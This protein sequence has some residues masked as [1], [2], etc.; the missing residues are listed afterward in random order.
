MSVYRD[1]NADVVFEHPHPGPL[2]ATVYRDGVSIWSA[3]DL[4]PATPGRYVISLTWKETAVDGTLSIVWT[5][6]DFTRQQEVEVVTPVVSISRLRTI[7]DDVNKTDAELAELEVSVRTI[8]EAYTGQ[9]FNYS[10]G[11]KQ[12]RTNGG[13]AIL[14]DRLTTLTSVTGPQGYT[15]RVGN[16]GFTVYSQPDPSALPT[17]EADVY[18]LADDHVIRAPGAKVNR[19]QDATYTVTGEWGYVAVPEDV[20]E[21]AL[22]LAND[23]LT[24]DAGYRDRYLYILKIQQDSFTYHSGAYRGTGNA[25]ADLLLAKHRRNTRMVI[26]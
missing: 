18:D 24:G 23:Y 3:E 5:G 14:D 26:L 6:D 4:T 21:A 11:A 22:L 19:Y 10:V 7:Y 12:V 1:T 15:L 25:R 8:I 20:Q 17:R 9:K 13:K 16:D 2:T